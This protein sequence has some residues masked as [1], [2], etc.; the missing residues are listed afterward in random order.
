MGRTLADD[1]ERVLQAGR[2]QRRRGTGVLYQ[3]K[4]ERVKARRAHLR[5]RRSSSSPGADPHPGLV[6]LITTSC[7]DVFELLQD[8]QL[9]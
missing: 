6:T 8:P 7:T 3:R 4:E 5:Q 9:P 2:E 1:G